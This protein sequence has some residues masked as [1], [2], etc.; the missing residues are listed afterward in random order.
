MPVPIVYGQPFYK[1]PGDNL[2][3]IGPSGLVKRI[4][5]AYVPGLFWAGP[6]LNLS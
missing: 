5:D 6:S 1:S 4:D 3:G 2:I